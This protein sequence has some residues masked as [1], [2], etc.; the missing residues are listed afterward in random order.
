MRT[1]VTLT[2]EA[3][4]LVQKA[5]RERGLSFK[6][7]VNSAIVRGLGPDAPVEPFSTPVFDL[8]AA[9]LPVERALQLA[10]ELEDEALLGKTVLGK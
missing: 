8:G 9:R 3:A 7:V 10:G 5:M 4:M 2:P 1:T 6:E